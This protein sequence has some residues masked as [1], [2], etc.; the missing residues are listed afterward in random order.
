MLEK[1]AGT[2]F[3]ASFSD[4]DALLVGTGRR[5]PNDAEK[6]EPGALAAKLPLGLRLPLDES[7]GSRR[8]AI[9]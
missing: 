7:V 9:S 6:A 5:A 2:A 8:R 4:T 3:L 1:I